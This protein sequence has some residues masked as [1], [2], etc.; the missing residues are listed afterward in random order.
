M[1]IPPVESELIH[2]DEQTDMMKLIIAFRKFSNARK[3]IYT[4]THTIRFLHV[5]VID[6]YSK[7]I[8]IT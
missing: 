3:I 8:E 4:L 6:L 5:R 2:V 1:T 7:I